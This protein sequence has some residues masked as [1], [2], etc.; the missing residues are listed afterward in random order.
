MILC[1][2]CGCEMESEPIVFGEYCDR[3]ACDLLEE[4]EAEK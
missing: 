1:V 3:C 2:R 4:L